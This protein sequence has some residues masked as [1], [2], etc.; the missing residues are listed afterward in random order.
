MVDHLHELRRPKVPDAVERRERELREFDP[1]AG[2][3]HTEGADGTVPS[4]G[5]SISGDR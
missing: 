3:R 5:C 4:T 2:G 1:E